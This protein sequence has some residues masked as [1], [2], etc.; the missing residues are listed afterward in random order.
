MG[1]E[2]ADMS[3]W[4]GLKPGTTLIVRGNYMYD[5]YEHDFV[6]MPYD[7]LQ[8]EREQRQ[9]TA[10]DGEKRV[11][12]HLHTKSSSMDGFTTPARSCVWLTAWATAPLPSPT[13]VSARATPKRCWPPMPSTKQ[14]RTLN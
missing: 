13:T 1:E 11:E 14:T 8:V 9:D 2:G 3:K 6:I 4:E 10:P 12:L 5:K 7:V